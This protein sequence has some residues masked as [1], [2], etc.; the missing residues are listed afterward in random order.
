MRHSS[1]QKVMNSRLWKVVLPPI[2]G[3]GCF[4]DSS[5]YSMHRVPGG[6][7]SDRHVVKFD[8]REFD[9]KKV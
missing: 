8:V 2:E 6:E 1:E 4:E 5:M 9:F 7:Q 3:V